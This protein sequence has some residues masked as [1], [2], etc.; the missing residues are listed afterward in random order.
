[1]DT[2]WVIMDVKMC[3]N[4]VKM[5]NNDLFQPL[6]LL[7]PEMLLVSEASVISRHMALLQVLYCK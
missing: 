4:D 1:M 7:R 2:K 6:I 5:S 3:K